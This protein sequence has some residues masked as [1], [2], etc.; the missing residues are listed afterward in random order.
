MQEANHI[1]RE[2]LLKVSECKAKKGLARIAKFYI[3]CDHA[4]VHN[5]VAT[6]L[7][8]RANIWPHPPH[9]PDCNKPIEHV[10]AQVDAGMQQWLKKQRAQRPRPKILVE[11]AKAEC[12]KVFD[13]IPL[14]SIARDVASLPQTWQAIVDRRGGFVP[15][16]LS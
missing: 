8:N 5:Q 1:V 13:N 4:S 2:L 7:A 9:S 6:V 14:D 16:A 11:D 10:H 3:C 15:D 12:T